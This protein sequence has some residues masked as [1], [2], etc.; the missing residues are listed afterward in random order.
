M[1]LL[2]I[3]AA[4]PERVDRPVVAANGGARR[5]AGGP[6]PWPH[7]ERVDRPYNSSV[8]PSMSRDDLREYLI[9]GQLLDEET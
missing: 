9:R 2:R 8:E 3:P 4:K 6:R 1:G 7:A 5:F